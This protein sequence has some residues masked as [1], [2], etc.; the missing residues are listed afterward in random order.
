MMAYNRRTK[1]FACSDVVDLRKS[2]DGLFAAARDIFNQ[3]P[4]SGHLFVFLNGK[5]TIC[6]C[7][8]F[9]GTGLVVLSKRLESGVF[10]RMN[11]NLNLI[12][13][14]ESEFSLF[15]EGADLSKRFIES[16]SVYK[17]K[18][19]QKFAKQNNIDLNAAG[20]S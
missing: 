12:E 3:D 18:Y 4:L 7:L 9:D 13:M 10:Y 6:K 11:P 20:A 2:F 15:F 17:N 16:P 5:R 1:V 19:V 14:T 8:Y